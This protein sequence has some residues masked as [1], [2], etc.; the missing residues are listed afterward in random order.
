MGDNELNLM[1]RTVAKAIASRI[2]LPEVRPGKHEIWLTFIRRTGPSDERVL[3]GRKRVLSVT[4]GPELLYAVAREVV[5]TVFGDEV[6]VVK[7][8]PNLKIRLLD[9]RADVHLPGAPPLDQAGQIWLRVTV[10]RYE[11]G[12]LERIFG[13][14]TEAV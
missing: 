7:D 3:P 5:L 1:I 9:H 13:E 2:D 11:P 12:L 14:R 10:R 4:T 6:Q 8:L